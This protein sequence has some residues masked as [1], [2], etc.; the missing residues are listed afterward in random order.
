MCAAKVLTLPPCNLPR[1]MDFVPIKLILETQTHKPLQ[2]LRAKESRPTDLDPNYLLS[3][4]TGS[5]TKK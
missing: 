4:S 2:S 3:S 5:F 1:E